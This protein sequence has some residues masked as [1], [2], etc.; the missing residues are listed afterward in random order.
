MQPRVGRWPFRSEG[1]NLMGG[2]ISWGILIQDFSA[3]SLGSD[4]VGF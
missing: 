1:G 2:N 4:M 3:F